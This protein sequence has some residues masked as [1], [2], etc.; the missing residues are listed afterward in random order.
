MQKENPTAKLN[1]EFRKRVIKAPQKNGK[2]LI[3]GGLVNL[4]SI[5]LTFVLC[6]I[7]AYSLTNFDEDNDPYGEHDFGMVEIEGIPQVFWKID[8]YED[9]Q[10][11]YG[12]EDNTK[13]Y[14]VLTIMFASDY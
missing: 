11:E 7:H 12:A 9:A 5:P 3:A 10:L 1:D 6:A 14:R 4:S 2:L 13:A 8:Y